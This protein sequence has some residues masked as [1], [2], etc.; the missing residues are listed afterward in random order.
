MA[1]MEKMCSENVNH[2]TACVS[3][4]DHNYNYIYGAYSKYCVAIAIPMYMYY[5]DY[6]INAAMDIKKVY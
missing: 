1:N 3:N 5:I 2:D 6:A 4:C